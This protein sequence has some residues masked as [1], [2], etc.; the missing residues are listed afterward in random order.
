MCV[1]IYIY[2][3]IYEDQLSHFL[4]LI[5]V[6]FRFYNH[7]DFE[8][9][10]L[11]ALKFFICLKSWRSLKN[12]FEWQLF[13]SLFLVKFKCRFQ[14]FTTLLTHFTHVKVLSKRFS[15]LSKFI[16]SKGVF[17]GPLLCFIFLFCSHVISSEFSCGEHF[18]CWIVLARYIN[19]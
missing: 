19:Y 5:K 14:N 8:I 4:D 18:T 10:V 17:N 1:Y 15:L 12:V 2:I 16:L 9:C 6:C 11:L 7:Q 3:Y 13:S